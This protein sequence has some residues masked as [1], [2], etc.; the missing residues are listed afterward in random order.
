MS[1]LRRADDGDEEDM[2]TLAI[3]GG[4]GKEGAG[5]AMR[6]ALH[7]HRVIIGSRVAEKA[8]SRADEMNAELGGDYLRGLENAE[9]AAEAD[10][11]IL[12][13]PYGAHEATLTAVRD[14][15]QGKILVDLTVP[16]KPPEIRSVNLPAGGAAALEAQALL[17]PQVAVVAAFQNVSAVKLRQLDQAVDCDVLVCADDSQAKAAVIR[18]V[19]AARMR[20]IDAGGL[21]NAVAAEALTPVLMHIN[22]TYGVR[23]AG[24]RITGLDAGK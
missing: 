1:G 20:G 18:L 22:K 14:A 3:L 9:A 4:T 15:C 13:V 8:I 5:L 16:L 10:I 21:K 11:V 6:W 24:L 2:K 19:S 7:G 23:G 12:S 17:G